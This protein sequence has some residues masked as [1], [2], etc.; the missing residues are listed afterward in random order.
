MNYENDICKTRGLLLLKSGQIY[1]PFL[2]IDKVQDILIEDGFIKKIASEINFSKDCHVLDC[3]GKII[4]NGFVDLHAH[5][6]E[7]GFEFKET[8][9]TGS[10]SAFFGGYTRVC[11]MPNTNPVV[12][13]PELVKYLKHKAE[14][15]PIYLYPI[16]AI[17]KGQEGKELSEV[18]LMVEAGAVAISD[19]GIPVHNSQILRMALEYTKK[20]NIP[21]INHAEDIFLVNHGLVNEGNNSLKLGLVG[22]PDISEA[23]MVYRDLSIAEYISGR[24]HI[25]HVSS[26]KSVEIIRN[27]KNKGVKV[28]SEVTPHHLCLT[29]DVLEKYDTN[30]KVAPPIRSVSD[31]AALISAI[32]SGDINCIATDHA[33]HAIED[34]EKDFQHASCGM[35]GMESAFGLVNKTLREAKM[36]TKSIIDLFTINPSNI[37]NVSP[38]PIEEGVT[39]EINIVDPDCKWIFDKKDIKSKSINTPLIGKELRGKVLSTI[40]KGFISNIDLFKK[41]K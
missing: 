21:V 3:K 15:T 11:V 34:K 30:A 29:D 36:S 4:T 26:K 22:N 32:K 1:D 17:T 6:R 16:G 37:L 27:F 28:T 12:D 31:R 7:P 2:K 35:I 9:E 41:I 5:F 25:P 13:S 10:M 20:F 18:G 23:T 40:N 8:V 38:S 33:P 19:D 39:A 14:K 24:L